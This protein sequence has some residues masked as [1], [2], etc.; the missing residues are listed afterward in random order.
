MTYTE[1]K[2]PKNPNLLNGSIDAM[3]FE[4]YSDGTGS[5]FPN[6]VGG[7]WVEESVFG[8]EKIRKEHTTRRFREERSLH[9]D[10]YN[11]RYAGRIEIICCYQAIRILLILFVRLGY[12]VNIRVNNNIIIKH[13]DECEQSKRTV[14]KS[15]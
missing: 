15:N 4:K 13:R 2:T 3:Y 9:K 11:I 5:N 8:E 6:V 10:D 7:A 12:D 14:D 1:K